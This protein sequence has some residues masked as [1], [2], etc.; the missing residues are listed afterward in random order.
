MKN[1]ITGL[2]AIMLIAGCK[3]ADKAADAKAALQDTIDK[4]NEIA[5]KMNQANAAEAPYVVDSTNLTTIEW[6]DSKE[7]NLG[8][9]T[10]GE[11]LSISFRFK[12]NGTKPLV[13]SKAWA[14]CGC[15]V[16]ET[17]KEPF[18]PGQEGVIKAIFNSEGKGGF[19]NTKEVYVNANTSP[20]TNVLV[21]K[22]DVLKKN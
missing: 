19:L 9:I 8:K 2:F 21:F 18:A 3:Q 12:N 10:E 14:S 4:A 6:L 15:T 22:V 20:V 1:I 7:L 5:R 11:K 13:I 16:P 17:P